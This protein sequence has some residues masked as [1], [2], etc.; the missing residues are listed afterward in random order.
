MTKRSTYAR[1]VREEERRRSARHIRAL[2][3]MHVA[4]HGADNDV[5]KAL[6]QIVSQV[7]YGDHR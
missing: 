5:S 4:L 2:R 6:E 3:K 1:R 7:D